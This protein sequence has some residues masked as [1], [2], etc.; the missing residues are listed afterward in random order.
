M[1]RRRRHCGG[2]S[3]AV[4]PTARSLPSEH[5][6]SMYIL[7][8]HLHLSRLNTGEIGNVAF[9][10]DTSS[11][12]GDQSVTVKFLKANVTS[13]GAGGAAR[14]PLNRS[15]TTSA[16]PPRNYESLRAGFHRGNTHVH[17][18]RRSYSRWLSPVVTR[19]SA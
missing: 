4:P 16:P 9:V 10:D 19:Q 3:Q 14:C 15:S 7:G 13:E 18:T 8:C 11:E 17:A 12:F 6:F 2:Q 1:T 5:R